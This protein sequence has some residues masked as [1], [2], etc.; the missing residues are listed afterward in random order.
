MFNLFNLFKRKATSMEVLLGD[1]RIAFFEYENGKLLK[2]SVRKGYV[3]I[4]KN[5][6]K[7]DFNP[8]NLEILTRA[9]LL[10]RNQQK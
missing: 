8:D 7:S 3:L 1:N 5:G 2:V 10:K 4:H 9:Q 6:N